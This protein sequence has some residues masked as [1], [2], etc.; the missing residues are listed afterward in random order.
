MRSTIFALALALAA[1]PRLHAQAAVPTATQLM[2]LSAFG[3]V[4]GTYTGLQG[5]RNLGITAGVDLGVSS[6]FHYKPGIEVRG[7]FP[8]DSGGYVGEKSVLA[9]V[10]LEHTYFHIYRPYVDFLVGRGALDY[11]RGGYPSPDGYYYYVQ[12]PSNVLS[13]GAGLNFDFSHSFAAKAD[14]QFQRWNTPVTT[15]GH[16]YSKPLTLGIVYKFDFNGHHKHIKPYVEPRVPPPPPQQQ[17]TPTALE[18]APP[19]VQDQ[20]PPPPA[21][22]DQPQ[23]SQPAPPPQS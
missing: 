4:T 20:A 6:F 9:G 15:S 21:A 5:G 14:V 1:A 16:I 7:T 18:Q 11:Q 8:V 2:H 22:T 13:P 17:V 10:T 19:T 23:P 12:N 3:G